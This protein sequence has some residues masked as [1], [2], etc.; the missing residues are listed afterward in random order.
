MKSL[1]QL[2][3]VASLLLLLLVLY[4]VLG[5][6]FF[7]SVMLNGS[8]DEHANFQSF[9]LAMFTLFRMTTGEAWNELMHDAG[10]QRSILF[11]CEKNH[12]DRGHIQ[13]IQ[14]REDVWIEHAPMGCG[15]QVAKAYFVSFM[16]IV[17]I[18]FLN[19]FIAII[20]EGFSAS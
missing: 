1:R 11:Q 19:M 7:H 12:Q 14:Q 10:R 18:I 5:V 16:L 6:S 13:H 3:N 2:Y 20:L 17:S 8:L 4:S 15:N 9:S